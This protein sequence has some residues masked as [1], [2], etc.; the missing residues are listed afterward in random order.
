MISVR[1]LVENIVISI[2]DNINNVDIKEEEFEGTT[3]FT[4]TVSQ[5]DVGKLIGRDGRVASAIRTIA[6]ASGAKRGQRILVN[7]NNKPLGQWGLFNVWH[8]IRYFNK[9]N[10]K[11]V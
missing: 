2:I 8:Q 4:I 5:E 9:K 3:L 1:S 7:V 10:S 11:N 6:K